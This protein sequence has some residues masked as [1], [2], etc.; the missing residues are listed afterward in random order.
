MIFNRT[1]INTQRRYGSQF[2]NPLINV[3]RSSKATFL[4]LAALCFCGG[5]FGFLYYSIKDVEPKLKAVER[6][7]QYSSFSFEE[8]QF[9]D[10]RDLDKHYPEL[11]EHAQREREKYNSIKQKQEEDKYRN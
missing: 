6:P 11:H 3:K 5:T 2:D 9:I 10:P 4:T 1:R 7:V 8:S